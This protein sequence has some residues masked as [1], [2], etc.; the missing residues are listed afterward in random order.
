MTSS[1]W[2]DQPDGTWGALESTGFAAESE[3]QALVF[4]SIGMLPLAGEPVVVPLVREM[5]VPFTKG[6]VDVVAVESDGT[7]VLIEVKLAKSSE[8]RKAVV[9]Q[10]LGYAASL[11]GIS[12][13]GLETRLK[14][15]GFSAPSVAAHVSESIPVPE[16]A[17]L[18]ALQ[19]SLEHGRFRLVL[20]LDDAPQEL[21]RLVGYLEAISSGLLAIDLI[22]VATYAVGDR[23]VAVPQR[24]DPTRVEPPPDV[25]PPDSEAVLSERG[26]DL[27][28]G[29]IP[30]APPEH[31]E[32]LGQM[33]AWARG[34][35]QGR[36]AKLFTRQGAART[37]LT[38]RLMSEEAGLV[39]LWND[40]GQPYLWL[41]GTVWA[42][43][44]PK[45]YLALNENLG[46]DIGFRR[47]IKWTDV[48]PEML[49]IIDDA[50]REAS[51]S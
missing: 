25:K 44:A 8:A 14:A 49:S 2:I 17:F 6:Q 11:R 24:L 50:Y 7:L 30:S 5:E 16:E 48:T 10:L 37:V 31:H 35:E 15:R 34:L 36:L 19:S 13:T 21:V 26:S 47:G 27:F 28:T 9:S 29:S 20:V 22:T 40:N 41:H 23:R 45:A 38:P 43:T 1:I 51:T 42:R 4:R 39:A 46:A 33:A 12:L 32:S 3:L 18:A